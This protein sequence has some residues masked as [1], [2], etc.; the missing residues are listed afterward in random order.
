MILQTEHLII[1]E[2][3]ES[4]LEDLARIL[5]NAEVMRFSLTGKP[6]SKHET[7]KMLK[8]RILDH[9]AQHGFGLWALIEK[10]DNKLIGFAGLITQEIDGEELIELGYRLHPDYWGQGLA[11]E[12]CKA[13]SK[14]AF[15]KLKLK[16]IISIIDPRNDRSIKVADRVPMDFWKESVFHGTP[17]HIYVAHSSS[18]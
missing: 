5:A 7:Q 3:V 16:K 13:I 15:E 1:R 12:A 10:Q 9:Y 8:L 17:V 2:F 6:L 14:Y 11:T 18:L 4:D